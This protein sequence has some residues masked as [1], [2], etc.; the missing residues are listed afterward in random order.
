MNSTSA[1]SSILALRIESGSRF[2]EQDHFRIQ[3]QDRSKSH[4]LLFS[5][6]EPMRRAVS[7]SAIPN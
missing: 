3:H 2:V 1:T 7:D 5:A 6:R 4:T